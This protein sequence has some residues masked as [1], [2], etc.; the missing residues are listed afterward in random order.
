MQGWA[1]F[2][3]EQFGFGF[4]VIPILLR[5]KKVSFPEVSY[6]IDRPLSFTRQKSFISVK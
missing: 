3:F 5:I 4:L 2:E 6:L 1:S